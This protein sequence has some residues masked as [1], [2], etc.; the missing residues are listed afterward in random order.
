L[1]GRVT[2]FHPT[3]PNQSQQ[4]VLDQ[5]R[6]TG[7]SNHQLHYY[8]EPERIV[9]RSWSPFD[10]VSRQ[11]TAHT[12]VDVKR[13]NNVGGGGGGGGG[14]MSC[15]PCVPRLVSAG[16][17]VCGLPTRRRHEYQSPTSLRFFYARGCSCFPLRRRGSRRRNG[18]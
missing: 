9:V 17:Y 5:Y 11:R 15:M 6:A 3:A 18:M 13:Q 10:P 2:A 1:P 7:G 14:G 4:L 12:S 8:T 16:G